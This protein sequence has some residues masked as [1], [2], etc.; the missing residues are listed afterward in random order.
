MYNC[1]ICNN[2]QWIEYKDENGYDCVRPCKCQKIRRN[3]YLVQESGLGELL[4]F[5]PLITIKPVQSGNK[6]LKT[7]LYNMLKSLPINGL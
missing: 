5:V 2:E 7:M 3:L 4:R 6:A 1:P